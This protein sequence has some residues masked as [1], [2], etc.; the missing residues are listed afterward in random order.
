MSG[1]PDPRLGIS[2]RIAQAFLATEITPLLALTGLLLGLFAV[3]VTPREE[4]PQINVTFANVFIP[5]PGASAQEVE[6]L[7]TTPAE[8][9]VSE[10][11][12]VE[13]V[14][15]A[16]TPGMAS[17]T[18]RFEVG[19]PRTDAIVRLY[20]AFYSNQDWLPPGAGV[21]Q[22][23]IKPKGIDD[24]PIVAGT[25]WSENPDVTAADLL[26][27]AHT[28]EAELQRVPGTR[29]IE[30]LGGPERVVHVVF[31]PQRLAGYGLALDDL[32]RALSTANASTEAGRS[33][34][35]NREVLVQAGTFLM[36]PE[37]VADLVVGVRSGAPVFLRDVAA[38]SEG[39]DQPERYVTHG[40]GSGRHPAVTITVSKKPGENAVDVAAAVIERFEQMRGIHFPDGVQATV[41]RNYGATAEDKAQTLIQKLLFATASVIVLVLFT[42]GRR[43]ALVVGAA[44]VVTLAVTLFA[45]WAWGF[46]LNRVSLFAL[47][48]S[49]G[50]LVD[51]AIVVVENIHRHMQQGGRKLTEAIPAAVDEVGGPTILATF[52][53]IAALLPMAFVTGLMGPYMRPIPINASTGMLISLAVAFVFTPWL[54]RRLFLNTATAHA[55][56]GPSEGAL[57]RFFARIMTRF[58]RQDEGRRNRWTL[59]QVLLGLIVLSLALVAFRGVML[60]MLPFDNKSEFQVLVDMPEGTPVEETQRALQA[61]ADYVETVPEVTDYQT[62][63][64]ASAP[65]NFNGLVRQYYLRSAPHQGD[66]QVNLQDKHLRKRKSHEIA[67]SA[68]TPT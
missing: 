21:G 35:R 55:P 51:D 6:S 26:R 38:V 14:Y 17:L 66:I 10:I 48:F 63:A 27:I 5:Y 44:V 24:V 25:L 15:S 20:N 8:Q 43:E 40:T 32:R 37:E 1:S 9:I 68:T 59:L 54:Y 49:I 50:I 2:G 19:E 36:T 41:T 7:V 11:E 34:D 23:L 12:G 28:M 67:A 56:A 61:L 62:Y 31:D 4:E 29:D 3:A 45:S 60:K 18:V 30:T 53:V 65:I 16:S 64:G 57:H 39:P 33:V 22:P 52:T 13:H 47:I 58:L 46:T 42:L